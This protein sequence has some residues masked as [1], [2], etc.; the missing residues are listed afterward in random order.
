MLPRKRTKLV[1]HVMPFHQ[2]FALREA[3]GDCEVLLFG[4]SRLHRTL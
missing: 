3:V 1:I 4:C 2:R